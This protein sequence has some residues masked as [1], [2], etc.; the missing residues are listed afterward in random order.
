M[1]EQIKRGS[2][3]SK[4]DALFQLR[5][6][7][8]AEASRIAVPALQDSNEIVRVTATYS[9]VYL[10]SDE[11]VQVLLPLLKDKSILV[12]KET[13]YALGKT[14]SSIGVQPLLEILQK[15]K[16]FEVRASS[17]VAL[18]E[19]G[20]ISAVTELLKI[21]QT[22]SKDGED[23]LR[24]A[25]ARGIGQIAQI[26]QVTLGYVVTPE[27]LL[28]EKYD[29]FANFKYAN[30]AEKYPQFRQ[31]VSVLLSVLQNQKESDDVRREAAFALGTIGDKSAI[32]TLQN[33]LS[34]NDYYL[35]EICK[36]GLQKIQ[37]TT[38]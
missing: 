27:S 12:R 16:I 10:Q 13:A 14:K 38:K 32:L 20:D 23:F 31:S 35:A 4:R 9:V 22:K 6:L 2:V 7:E 19:I 25:V 8:T 1:A 37:S 21:L 36:E 34:S 15:D 24:R 33:N 3:E 5:N 30:L 29:T 28:P 26:Q 11:A 17:V 18:G